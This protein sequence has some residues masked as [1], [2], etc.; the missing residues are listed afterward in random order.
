[1][2]R[3]LMY[4]V[5]AILAVFVLSSFTLL[6][7]GSEGLSLVRTLTAHELTTLATAY[8][9]APVA[10][11]GQLI[12]NDQLHAYEVTDDDANYPTPLKGL[13]DDVY[14]PLVGQRVHINGILR[15]NKGIEIE[16]DSIRT[17]GSATPTPK[18]TGI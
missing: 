4:T 6:K 7:H 17:V 3:F 11:E 16:V 10:V 8:E 9:D 15:M 1:M 2:G 5:I 14:A 18:P 13:S 12:Y